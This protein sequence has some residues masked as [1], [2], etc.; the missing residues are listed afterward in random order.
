MLLNGTSLKLGCYIPWNGNMYGLEVM[1]YMSG[2]LVVAPTNGISAIEHS[3]SSTN[4]W[5]FGTLETYESSDTKVKI[6]E[7]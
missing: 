5:M 7:Y 1:S 3:S 6:K 2:T 4:S